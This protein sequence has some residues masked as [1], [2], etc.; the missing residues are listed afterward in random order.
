M[1]YLK[2]ILT[3]LVCVMA[4]A[5]CNE[6]L[7]VNVN[8]ETPTSA[9]AT[10]E[11]RLPWCEYYVSLTDGVAG[12]RTFMQ[13]GDWT[14]AGG[15][16]YYPSSV[17]SPANGITTTAYQQFF[18]G[19]ACNFEDLY[20]K[21]MEV[22]AYHYAACVDVFR[23]IGY[24]AMTDL[25]GEMPYSEACG[26]DE[27][28][29]Y[30][31]GKQIF[32]GCLKDL[33]EAIELFGKTQ[34]EGAPALSTCDWWNGG[35]I[36]KW[37]KLCWLLKARY[38]V[39]LS[40]KGAGSITDGKYDE[41]AILD[42]LSKGPQS[43]ADDT[44]IDFLDEGTS[45]RVAIYGDPSDICP[46]YSVLGMNSGYMVSAAL[47]ANLTNFDGKGVEDPRADKIIPWQVSAKSADTPDNVKFSGIWRRSVGVDLVS[48]STPTLTGG[49]LRSS[50]SAAKGWY[51]TS[52]NT[53][54][55]ADTLFVEATCGSTGYG[56][57]PDLFFRRVSG[58]NQSRESG[59]FYA[60]ADCPQYVGSYCEACF[61]KAEVLFNKNDKSGAFDAYK[62][63]IQANFDMM[64]KALR[65]WDGVCGDATCPSFGEMSAADIAYYMNNAIGTAA[66]LTL[67][68][69][70]TQK[71]LAMQFSLQVWNDMRRYDYNPQI[72][73]NWHI[74]YMYTVSAASQKAIPLG[75][76]WRRW[77]QCSHE[78]NYN[79]VNLAAIG[80]EV[81]GAN[82]SLENWNNADDVWTIPVWWD[83][84][85]P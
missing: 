78:L 72:F 17:W 68:K 47:E 35:D 58:N 51:I 28:P 41:A 67:G 84:T 43:I 38:G 18:V 49:P 77:R 81:P 44:A 40:K 9:S 37:T 45:F 73:Q 83:S 22:G 13:C 56:G 4:L 10:I 52:D 25:Y 12:F 59:T 80:S 16:N 14:R 69:I 54:R 55:L 15:S 53:A 36:A 5:S 29:S 2:S 50:Y 24:M 75:K 23:A 6:W 70:M 60:R 79:S 62:K 66:D 30:D 65:K 21:A 85:Q 32:I 82:T 76:D 19:G 74:P 64:N 7:D 8:P 63:G 39:K 48:S 42:A 61:I 33:D 34:E 11:T 46:Y 3:A 71:K 27:T 31:T 1:K 26:P 20:N 57:E